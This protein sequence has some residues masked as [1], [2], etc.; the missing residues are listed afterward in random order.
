MKAVEVQ[1]EQG[2][3]IK[4]FPDVVEYYESIGWKVV[5]ELEAEV[6]SE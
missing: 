4:V 2:D 1:N 5:V 6:E 3:V